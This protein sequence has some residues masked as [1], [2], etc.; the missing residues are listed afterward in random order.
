[1][2]LIENI[3]NEAYQIHTIIFEENEIE[4]V[5]RF[6]P[7][8]QIWCYDVTYKEN[9]VNGIKL[10]AGVL[11]MRSRNLPFDFIIETT[12]GIDPFRIDDF[13]EGRCSLY[14]LTRA[15]ME[16]VRNAEVSL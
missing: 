10:T 7:T 14:M 16:T 8:I 5:L 2:L 6:Y 12:E 11:H 9:S 4:L 13:S 15:D 1:M 3:S